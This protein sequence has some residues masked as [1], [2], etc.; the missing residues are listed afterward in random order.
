MSHC[1]G[2]L[3]YDSDLARV[4]AVGY[5]DPIARVACFGRQVDAQCGDR[6]A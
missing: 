4:G 2:M 5:L 1:F 6:V 3:H